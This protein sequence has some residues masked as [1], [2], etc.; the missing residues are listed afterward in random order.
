MV[1]PVPKR[2]TTSYVA[3]ADF[4][5][6]KPRFEGGSWF[7]GGGGSLNESP[8]FPPVRT[9]KT[10]SRCGLAPRFGCLRCE[11]TFRTGNAATFTL[12]GLLRSRNLDAQI[13]SDFKSNPQAISNRGDSNH[14]DSRCH[15]DHLFHSDFIIEFFRGAS[16]GATTFFHFRSA[17][18][19]L[20]KASKATLSYL[21]L[22]PRRGH[23]VKHHLIS[24]AISLA[25][26]DFKSQ[27][28]SNRCDSDVRF[29]H[30]R[31]RNQYSSLRVWME[32]LMKY[33]FSNARE[34]WTASP[35]WK[36]IKIRNRGPWKGSG[37]KC[38]FARGSRGSRDSREPPRLWTTKEQPTCRDSMN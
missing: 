14:C 1:R 17:P 8:T 37:Q 32:N 29:V 35:N 19:P 26:C 5:L 16:E 25:L 4:P 15:F 22:P 31:S 18:D 11:S 6:A 13:A 27:R 10:H 24:V 36:G 38:L 28:F 9:Q 12:Q 3:N 2:P 30:L 23:P 7:F 21:K 20:F 34:G 33:S